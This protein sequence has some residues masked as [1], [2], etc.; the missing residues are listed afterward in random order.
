MR[1]GSRTIYTHASDFE[2]ELE[3]GSGFDLRF[4]RLI[5]RRELGRQRLWATTTNGPSMT[6]EF[7]ALT[8]HQPWAALICSGAKRFETRSWA[9]PANL[10]GQRLAIHAGLGTLPRD[11]TTEDERAVEVALGIPREHWSELPKGAVV[12]IATVAGA[13]QVTSWDQAAR[14]TV[15]AATVG[16]PPLAVIDLNQDE[17]RFGDQDTGRWLWRLTEIDVLSPPVPAKGMQG[18]WRW[19]R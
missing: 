17:W 3:T 8:I 9:P 14:V 18:L 1:F 10:I 5:G 15:G 11:L 7:R 19:N 2:Y 16:S 6:T 4:L 13:Y 12:C